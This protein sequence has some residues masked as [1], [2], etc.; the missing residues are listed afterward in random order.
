M[1]AISNMKGTLD[2]VFSEY[3]RRR[4]ANVRGS[5]H[6]ISCGAE[7]PWKEADCGHYVS[8]RH[9]STRYCEKNCNAQCVACNRY[10]DGNI[11]GYKRGLVEKYGDGILA[12]LEAKKHQAQKMGDYEVRQLLKEYRAKL[13]AL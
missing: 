9:N 12:E 3:I 11:E 4:D 2:S 5:I 13:K 6:C 10:S 7:I 8:R 1:A